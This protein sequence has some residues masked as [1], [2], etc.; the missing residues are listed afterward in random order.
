MFVIT[1]VNNYIRQYTIDLLIV[2]VSLSKVD[3][4]WLKPRLNPQLTVKRPRFVSNSNV[5]GE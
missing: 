5:A 2:A 3:H 1:S 4:T